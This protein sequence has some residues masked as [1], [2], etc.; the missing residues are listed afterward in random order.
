MGWT[1]TKNGELLRRAEEEFD[2][3]VTA[4]QKLRYQQNLSGRT[5]AIIVLPTN[6]VRTVVS[7]LPAIEESLKRVQPGVFLTIPQALAFIMVRKA[8]AALAEWESMRATM[9]LGVRRPSVYFET[10][11]HCEN[12][13]A[14]CSQGV[15]FGRRALGIELFSKGDGSEFQRLNAIYN[16]GRHFH[17]GELPPGDLHAVWF[18][19]DSVRTHEHA[20]KLG[21]LRELVG[22]LG[23]IAK[24]TVEGPSHAG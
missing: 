19:G 3:F 8:V 4:D 18:S 13:I 16:R 2:V 22:M 23:R 15:E 14:A 7:L 9:A 1:G 12:C 6:Q 17:P 5:L 11:R 24:S 10:L 20:L 21:Q